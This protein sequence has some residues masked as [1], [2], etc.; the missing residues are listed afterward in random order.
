MSTERKE[1]TLTIVMAST[2]HLTIMV[3]MMTMVSRSANVRGRLV[4]KLQAS[5]LDQTKI[6]IGSIFASGVRLLSWIR[7]YR[8]GS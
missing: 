8:I 5:R 7:Q 1:Q 6:S 4:Q 3:S 2:T